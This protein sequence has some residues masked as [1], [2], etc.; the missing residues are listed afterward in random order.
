MRP[1][2]RQ[3]TGKWRVFVNAAHPVFD[4]WGP[5]EVNFRPG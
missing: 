2:R 5:F 1:V 3:Y 4:S